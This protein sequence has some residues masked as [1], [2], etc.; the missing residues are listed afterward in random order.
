MI[1]LSPFLLYG[2][3][4]V[5]QPLEIDL[6][7]E[8]SSSRLLF[9]CGIIALLIDSGKMKKSQQSQLMRITAMILTLICVLYPILMLVAIVATGN[10]FAIDGIGGTVVVLLGYFIASMKLSNNSFLEGLRP[11]LT[12]KV[13]KPFLS[14]GNDLDVGFLK[15]TE[16]DEEKK[17]D[18]EEE[19]DDLEFS[20]MEW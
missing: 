8:G 1:F 19:E 4:V 7:K 3:L 5:H 6:I 12:P 13:A 11:F 9:S 14:L 16:D 17:E 20:Y 2:S 18:E 15:R 10:H